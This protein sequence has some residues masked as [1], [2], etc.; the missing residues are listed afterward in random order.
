MRLAYNYTTKDFAYYSPD[1]ESL[2]LF[3]PIQDAD[4]DDE[5]IA[6]LISNGDTFVV[7]DVSHWDGQDLAHF[8][9]LHDGDRTGLME[10]LSVIREGIYGVIGI[11]R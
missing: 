9:K 10:G 1:S 4:D 2:V 11:S 8:G 3:T 5:V 6:P 7:Y